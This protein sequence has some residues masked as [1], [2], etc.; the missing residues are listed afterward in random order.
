LDD[1]ASEVVATKDTTENV[2]KNSFYFRIFVE[3]FERFS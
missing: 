2:D 3:K 1:G